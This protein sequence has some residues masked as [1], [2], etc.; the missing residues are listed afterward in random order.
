MLK[1]LK[2]RALNDPSS[3]SEEEDEDNPKLSLEAQVRGRTMVFVR[4][5]EKVNGGWV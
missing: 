5:D 2:I 4:L 1:M 3:S